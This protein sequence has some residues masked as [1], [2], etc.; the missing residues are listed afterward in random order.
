VPE[1]S[2]CGLKLAG[3]PSEQYTIPFGYVFV[4]RSASQALKQVIAKTSKPDLK[5]AFFLIFS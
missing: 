5:Q 3:L 4:W 2:N 1:V